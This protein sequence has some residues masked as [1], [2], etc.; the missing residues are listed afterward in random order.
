[1]RGRCSG[2]QRTAKGARRDAAFPPIAKKDFECNL[3]KT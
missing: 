1:M 2:P 3:I